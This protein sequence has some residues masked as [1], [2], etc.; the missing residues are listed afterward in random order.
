MSI[1]FLIFMCFAGFIAAFVDS[2]A[3]GGGLISVPAYMLIGLPPAMVN[4]TNKFSASSASFTSSIKF[5]KSKKADFKILK[6]AL[7]FTVIG[8]II[9][10]GTAL[11]IPESFLKTII[12]VLIIFIGIYTYFSKKLGLD[13][14]FT[15]YTTKNIIF[16]CIL[17]LSIGFYDGFFGPGTGTFLIFGLI[18]IFG[19]DFTKASGNARVM[20]FTSNIVALIVYAING[21]IL[22]AYGIPVA[23]FSIIGARLGTQFAL[24]NG[25][26]FIKPIFIIISFLTAL[27]MIV[28]LFI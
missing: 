14:N 9:G 20:N 5:I 25:A 18:A 6:F 27:K 21:K 4:G 22:Y 11:S 7:P 19:F 10:A 23:V 13:E 1:P 12:S 26:K 8:S 2:I 3:G 17:A 28:E 16:T 24:K 15:G